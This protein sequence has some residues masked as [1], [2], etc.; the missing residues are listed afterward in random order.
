MIPQLSTEKLLIVNAPFD[1]PI[2]VG[3]AF[4]ARRI[5]SGSPRS[6]QGSGNVPSRTP[7]SSESK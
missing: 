7:P 5:S 6:V 1:F 3:I 4:T 2:I